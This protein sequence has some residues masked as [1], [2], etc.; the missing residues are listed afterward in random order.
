VHGSTLRGVQ[1]NRSIV[2]TPAATPLHR[3]RTV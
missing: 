2:P 1:G 3:M